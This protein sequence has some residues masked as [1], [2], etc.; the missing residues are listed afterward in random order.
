MLI[1]LYK[2]VVFVIRILS[3]PCH[4]LCRCAIYE[5]LEIVPHLR[6]MPETPWFFTFEIL[7]PPRLFYPSSSSYGLVLGKTQ[8]FSSTKD[9][10]FVMGFK[11]LH[12]N[13]YQDWLKGLLALYN[14]LPDV[15]NLCFLDVSDC[16][17]FQDLIMACKE[18]FWNHR[19]LRFSILSEVY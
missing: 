15:Y 2:C 5:F 12:W 10:C 11:I 18:C 16:F 1:L 19:P 17:S 8:M 13:S 14:F 9:F 3:Y 7:F 6:F 4:N